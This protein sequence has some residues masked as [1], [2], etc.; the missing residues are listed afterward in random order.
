LAIE[1]TKRKKLRE[2]RQR[3]KRA[4]KAERR[5][6]GKSFELRPSEKATVPPLDTD[7]R[8]RERDELAELARVVVVGD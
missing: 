1:H 6:R 8:E 4:A 7:P 3:K 2:E 5:G